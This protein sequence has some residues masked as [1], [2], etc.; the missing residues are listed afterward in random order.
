MISFL[1][2]DAERVWRGGQDQ[3]F[4]L[5][6]GL[7]QRGHKVH[8]ICHPGTLLE[9]RAREV[10]VHVHPMS[11]R[12]GTGAIYFFRI[13]SVM[14]RTRPQILAFNTPKPMMLGTLASRFSSVRARIVFRRV[15]F[16]LRRNPLTRLK[17]NWGIDCIVAISES[18]RSQLQVGGVKPSRIRTVYEGMEVDLY[19]RVVMPRFRP[20][21]TPVTIG[22]V[23]HL[24]QEKGLYYLVEAAALVPEVHER[25][26]FVL[27]GD[28]K[29]RQELES[30]VRE[31]GLE[32][33]FQFAGFQN[34][35][36]RYMS[37]FD[38]FV[39]PSLSE[40]LS[41]A[42]LT[43]MASSLPVIATN[44]GGIPELITDGE[45]GLLVPPADPIALSKALQRLAKNPE[46][47]FRMGQQGR[48]RLEQRFT[49]ER[50]IL[51]T[52]E[53]CRSLIRGPGPVSR[54]AHA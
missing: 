15:N 49:L 18:I 54:A 2:I 53:L 25:L 34:Q 5:L 39:L 3:L 48:A 44:V 45:N 41:S 6:R 21:G 17:Y 30:Q 42:I 16:P 26:R 33:C 27:V 40:G 14:L 43:A 24:S 22:T 20:P 32:P 13:L 9:E 4:T 19:P 7:C 8:L 50:K 46:E 36:G 1:F 37:T 51:E 11:M 10:G 31:R 28:G 47:C 12:S 29:C 35:P 23:A 52:E 38:I